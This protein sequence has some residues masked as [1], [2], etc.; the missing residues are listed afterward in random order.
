MNMTL[1]ILAAVLIL[2]FGSVAPSLADARGDAK[3]QVA[4]GIDMAQRGLWREAVYRWERAVQIDPTYAE[5]FNDLAVGYEHEGDFE[6]ARA[7][8]EKAMQL[9]PD[10]VSIRQNYELFREINDRATNDSR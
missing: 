4:F 5:A 2:T 9:Q 6:K 7:A 3:E 8:Y 10:S 1:R